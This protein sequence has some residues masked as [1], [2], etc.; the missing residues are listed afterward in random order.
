MPMKEFA[1]YIVPLL[2][3]A[4][5]LRRSMRARKVSMTGI[6]IRPAIFGLMLGGALAAGPVPPLLIL[7]AFV[8]AAAAGAGVGYLMA[9]HQHLTIDPTTGQ[10]SSRSTMIGT[11][12]ILGLFV[13]RFGAKAAFPEL[14]NP[15]HAAA[16]V[17]QA[18]NGL[19]V[20]T[21]AI[22]VT[23]SVLVWRRAQPMLA[24]HAAQKAVP[25]GTDPQPAAAEPQIQPTE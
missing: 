11:L 17:T 12:L 25:P 10:I 2:I 16:Q 20:F 5:I 8:V 24:A 3:V 21:V 7:A 14:A 4:L 23:Q 9:R 1:P 18:A 6:W 19:L 15:G 13:V 22:L